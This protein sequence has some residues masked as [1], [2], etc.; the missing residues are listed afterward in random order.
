VKGLTANQLE[1][2]IAELLAEK[3]LQDPHVSI[4]IREYRNQRISV[5][6]A[7]EKPGSLMSRDKR[8][9]WTYCHGRRPQG[10]GRTVALFDP[11]AE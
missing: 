1:K 10:G 9:F 11:A 7:V 6:G 8:R 2:E 4:F 3:Y 5:M